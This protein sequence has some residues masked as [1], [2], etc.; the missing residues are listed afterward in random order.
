MSGLAFTVMEFRHGG[1]HLVGE[2]DRAF[3][4]TAQTRKVVS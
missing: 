3:C 2:R 1:G 4:A